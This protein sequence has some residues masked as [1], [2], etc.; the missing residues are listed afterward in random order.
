MAP[1]SFL[2]GYLRLSLV[3]CPVASCRDLSG[4]KG[5]LPYD[6][7]S[8]ANVP[9]NS[10]SRVKRSLLAGGRQRRTAARHLD[11]ANPVREPSGVRARHDY[12]V[13]MAELELQEPAAS[14]AAE[15]R[16]ARSVS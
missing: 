11:L 16:L 2:K 3:T 9:W 5:K 14:V 10:A 12:R 15:R 13:K 8:L 6:R 4:P 1:R 7:Q